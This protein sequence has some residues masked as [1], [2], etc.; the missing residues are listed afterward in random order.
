[1]LKSEQLGS[2]SDIDGK[3]KKMVADA[4]KRQARSPKGGD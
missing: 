1:V 3:L 4:E 2:G